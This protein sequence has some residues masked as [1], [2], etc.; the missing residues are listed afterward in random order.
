MPH[1][2][3]SPSQRLLIL[4]SA[5]ALLGACSSTPPVSTVPGPLTATP[6]AAPLN[7]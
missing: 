5:A 1:L 4:C 2:S 7:I 6:L 3:L